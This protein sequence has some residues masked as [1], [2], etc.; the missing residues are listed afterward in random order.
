MTNEVLN[1]LLFQCCILLYT[2]MY[3]KGLHSKLSRFFRSRQVG[4]STAPPD[5]TPSE[6]GGE[7]VPDTSE[8]GDSSHDLFRCILLV[9]QF[10]L[11]LLITH[12]E[13]T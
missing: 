1:N 10:Y 3:M 4:S 9:E 12:V 2:R 8:L 7:N 5:T 11:C 6:E 13:P